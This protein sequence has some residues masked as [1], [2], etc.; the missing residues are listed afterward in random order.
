MS[1]GVRQE[2]DGRLCNRSSVLLSELQVLTGSY[3]SLVFDIFL[4]CLTVQSLTKLQ[5]LR[6]TFDCMHDMLSRTKGT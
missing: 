3:I 5:F 1:S 6:E 2:L 4:M